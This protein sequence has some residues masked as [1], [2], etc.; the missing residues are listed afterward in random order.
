MKRKEN[1]RVG[2]IRSACLVCIL[3]L[4]ILSI[5]GT[6]G[7]SGFDYPD[8]TMFWAVAANDLD[9]DG[10][11]DIVVTNEF[12]H[13]DLKT[14]DSYIS[15][16]L[17]DSNSPG[18]F[19]PAEKYNVAKNSKYF[20]TTLGIG[21]LNDDGFPDIATNDEEYIYI[22]FQDPSSPGDFLEP[23]KL[24]A[25]K[26][27]VEF[28]LAIGDL[29]QDGYN[30]IAIDG[31]SGP[32]LS[33]FFQ[34]STEP[35]NFLPLA[36]L[37]IKSGSVAIGDIDVDLRNDIILTGEG[38]VKL[39]FQ[40]PNTPG[41]FLAPVI[42]SDGKSPAGAKIG[43]LDKDGKPDLVIGNWGTSDDRSKGGVYVLLQDTANPG[44]FLPTG[45]YKFG[46][47]ADEFSLGDLNDD[48]LL[49]IAVASWCRE[50]KI[51]ILLQDIS[52]IGTFLPAKKYS[53]KP[54]RSDPW[55]IAIGDINNDN[56]NDLIVSED[57]VV[58]RFQDPTNPGTFLRRTTV[59]NP[60]E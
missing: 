53:C 3:A 11:V 39:L 44:E 30:D 32:R 9:G 26:H 55:S 48:G 27:T 42:F 21:D 6:G 25:G 1:I 31:Y 60:D 23:L 57:G 47:R 29:N 10:I 59:Y 40:D 2:F 38:V 28:A 8:F 43:D 19:F 36:S 51:T 58:I 33:I 45:S 34:D 20:G 52:T 41:K 37:G 17:N 54:K 50:C 15:V 56:F 14:T 13:N 49:D 35:G 24:V 7:N 22:L 12:V 46:C 16:I 5:L 18:A 4:G